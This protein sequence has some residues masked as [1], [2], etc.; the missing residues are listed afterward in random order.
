MTSPAI[1]TLRAEGK[2]AGLPLISWTQT[3]T[4]VGAQ[5]VANRGEPSDQRGA[6]EQW[7]RHLGA[8]AWPE[9]RSGKYICLRATLTPEGESRPSIVLI[10]DIYAPVGESTM[11]FTSR[12][13]TDQVTRATDASDGTYNVD[14]IVSEIVERYGAV[15]IDS[16]DSDEF[17]SVV[18]KHATD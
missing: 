15:D 7:T 4:G 16:L 8:R 6:F 17:W 14:A 1:Q 2:A 18:G 3:C 11:T 9:Q 5:G 10:A 13:L 12:D